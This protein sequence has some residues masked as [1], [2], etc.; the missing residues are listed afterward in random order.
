[1]HPSTKVQ[2]SITFKN[3]ESSEALRLYADEKLGACLAKFVHHDTEAHV[4]LRV[5]KNRQLA[6]ISFRTDG[7]HFKGSEESADMY[8]SIDALVDSL[9]KQLRKHKEKLTEHH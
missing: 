7:A 2:L 1:M 8:S 5:E 4:V 3:V 9:T 6:E